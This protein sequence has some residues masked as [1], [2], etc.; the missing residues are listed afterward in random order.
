[1]INATA[2]DLIERFLRVENVQKQFMTLE[3]TY[4]DL[5]KLE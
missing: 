5:T 4:R 3:S 1:M 2:W